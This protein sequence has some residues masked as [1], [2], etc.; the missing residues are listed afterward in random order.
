MLE[1]EYFDNNGEFIG[2]NI[3]QTVLGLSSTFE[4]NKRF[5][6]VGS[7]GFSMFSYLNI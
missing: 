4:L 5:N 6:L 3:V 2:E 1:V 7:F